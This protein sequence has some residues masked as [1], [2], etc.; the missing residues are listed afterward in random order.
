[1]QIGFGGGTVLSSVDSQLFR[2]Q[3]AA[4]LGHCCWHWCFHFHLVG[5]FVQFRCPECQGLVR[6]LI[7]LQVWLVCCVLDCGPPLGQVSIALC[8]GRASGD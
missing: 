3:M 5:E 4:P 8:W 6:G 2:L 7:Q 1:M